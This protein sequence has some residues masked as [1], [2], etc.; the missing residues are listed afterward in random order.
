MPAVTGTERA[1]EKLPRGRTKVKRGSRNGEE[2]GP[3]RS[4][5]WRSR[6]LSRTLRDPEIVLRS[7]RTK[8]RGQKW[9]GGGGIGR[10]KGG[11]REE[12]ERRRKG[13]ESVGGRY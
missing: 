8:L 10:G 2:G 11:V 9:V 1:K 12:R 4:G 7:Y 5:F 13:G 6:P 3:R